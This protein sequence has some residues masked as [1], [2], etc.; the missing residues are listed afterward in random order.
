[1]RVAVLEPIGPGPTKRLQSPDDGCLQVFSARKQATVDVNM[2]EWLWN[3]DF[4]KN[5]FR[6]YRAHTDY[7]IYPQGSRLVKRVR[8]ARDQ[9]DPEPTLVSLPPGR[10]EIQAEAEDYASTVE[11]RIPVVI[12]AGQTTT[13]HLVNGWKPYRQYSDNEVV[14]LPDG[15]IAGWLAGR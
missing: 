7:T 12:Q 11:G 14:R 10:Y 9:N 1:M 15:E 3:N 6:Y 4:G 5:E 2:E 8:Y 13:A